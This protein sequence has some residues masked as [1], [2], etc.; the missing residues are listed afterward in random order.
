MV[1][2]HSFHMKKPFQILSDLLHL[3]LPFYSIYSCTSS[4]LTLSIHDT[5]TK[6]LKLFISRTFTF[7]LLALL[8][9]NASAPYKYHWYNYSCIYR[10]FL[11]FISNPL[12]L[13]TLFSTPHVLYSSFILCTTS[14]SH[15]LISCHLQPQVLK[16]IHFLQ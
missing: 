3:Q 14:L 12:L 13:N 1:L 2:I 15:P 7:L 6:F 16:T 9:P 5:L 10:H 11:A 8:I 4:F